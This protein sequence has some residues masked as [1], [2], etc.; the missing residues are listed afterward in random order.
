MTTALNCLTTRSLSIGIAC[1]TRR[2]S[3]GVIDGT[4]STRFSSY[5][6]DKLCDYGYVYYWSANEQNGVRKK[7]DG[8][9]RVAPL[10]AVTNLR[11]LFGEPE[12]PPE[13]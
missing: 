11:P 5:S 12:S 2:G 1:R 13:G 9:K 7:I 10:K 4:R 3:S 6:R 8:Q